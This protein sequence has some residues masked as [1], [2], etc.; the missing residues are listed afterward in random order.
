MTMPSR[1][2]I[3]SDFM[4]HPRLADLARW[5][6]AEQPPPAPQ[7]AA[8][9]ADLD[10]VWRTAIERAG[11]PTPRDRV[12]D[13]PEREPAFSY[14]TPE[15]LTQHL[16]PAAV[17]LIRRLDDAA[18]EA[19]DRTVALTAHVHAAEDRAGRVS[20]DVAAA[21]R[22][23]GLPEVPDLAA[24]RALVERDRWPE[25]FTEPQR[26]HVRRIVAEGDRLAEAQGEV[27]RLRDRQRQHAAETAP[28]TA[29]R[30]R[31]VTALS[32]S[33]PPFKPVALPDVPRGKAEK[34][35][36]EAR[37]AIATEQAEVERISTAR[38][39][40]HEAFALALAAVERYGAESGLGAVV[41]WNGTEFTIREV[42]PGLS[43]EDHRPLRPLA[44][45]AA[46]L[47]RETAAAIARTIGTDPEA[48][49][50][51]DRPRVL[52]EA[53]ARLRQAE[54]LE[55]AALHALGDPL[56]RLAE[57]ADSDPLLALGVEAGR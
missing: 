24:A 46:I 12:A 21:I 4:S 9:S 57:R 53:R 20:L 37:A 10:P 54:L 33:R 40:E 19:R 14:R 45:F 18:T 29:L 49:N 6:T 5:M 36:A 30:N 39:N 47:P 51:K 1:Q 32:R 56:D 28:I 44:L 15:G 35:L 50:M 3:P 11:D 17:A 31:I 52:A 27:A 41:K 38:P 26:E 2:V 7:P 42:T 16:Q 43:T 22:S 8:A 23:A 13:A 55:R 34:A 25:R 48:P